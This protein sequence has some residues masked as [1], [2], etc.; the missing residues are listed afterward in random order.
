M[1]EFYKSNMEGERGEYW[2]IRA[3]TKTNTQSSRLQLE[4]IGER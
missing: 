1:D 3:K 4:H 2:A